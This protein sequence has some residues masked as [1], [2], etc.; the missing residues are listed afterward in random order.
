[1]Q[2]PSIPDSECCATV[3]ASALS[4]ESSRDYEKTIPRNVAVS[5]PRCYDTTYLKP[6]TPVYL[7]DAGDGHQY[8]KDVRS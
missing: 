6:I 4:P 8:Y 5:R 7:K 3:S 2:T 1:M